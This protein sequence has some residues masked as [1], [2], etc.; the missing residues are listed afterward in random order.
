M[1][2]GDVF[3]L[4]GVADIH[5]WAVI[6]DPALDPERVLLVNF[7]TFD[8]FVDQSCVLDVGDHPFITVRTCVNYPR[9]REARDADLEQLRA[10]GRLILLDPLRPE[11]L[12]RI[13]DR[14]MDSV[15]MAIE[16][17]DILIDQEL[18]E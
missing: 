18:V 15:D 5:T 13:R 9:A 4:G 3:R 1:I 17:A 11:I 6:S 14:A 2:A 8:R 16:L 10:A 7:T 12:K